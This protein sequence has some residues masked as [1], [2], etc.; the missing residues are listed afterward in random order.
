[1]IDRSLKKMRRTKQQK[2]SYPRRRAATR[3]TLE[4]SML[5]RPAPTHAS[6]TALTISNKKKK[7]THNSCFLRPRLQCWPPEFQSF[8]TSPHFRCHQNL[9]WSSLANPQPQQKQRKLHLSALQKEKKLRGTSII[10][11]QKK[12]H[13][14]ARTMQGV[15][16]APVCRANSVRK[17][18]RALAW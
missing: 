10:S 15:R 11:S 9:L 17:A 1:M 3:A 5:F 16:H 13:L 12:V 4:A 2:K 6:P 7:K 18:T 8:S 14:E